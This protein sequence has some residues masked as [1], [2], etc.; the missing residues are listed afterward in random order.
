[1]K[2]TP[3][4][5]ALL[6]CALFVV[7]S[8]TYARAV[9]LLEASDEAAHFLYT[10]HLLVDR[11]LPV[12]STREQ[13]ADEDDLARRWSVESHHPPLYYAIGALLIS[14]TQRADLEAYLQPNPLIFLRGIM[15]DNH[16]KWL[17]PLDA[18][19][20]TALAIWILRGYSLAL[21]VVTLWLIY[22][23]AT[24]AMG[25]TVGLIALLIAAH[26]PTLLNIGSSVNNDNLVTLLYTAGVYWTLRLWHQRAIRPRDILAISAIL[27]A[28]ALTK[29]TGLTLFAVVYGGVLLGVWRGHYPLRAALQLIVISLGVAAVGA[30]WWYLRNWTL[31]GDPIA[32]AM[33]AT[34][35][36]RE[37]AKPTE[38]GDL[39]A[40]LSRV[41]RSFWMMTGHLHQPVWGATWGYLYVALITVLGVAGI[42]RRRPRGDVLLLLGG[43]VVLLVT[44][45]A[46]GT[47]SIDISYGRL[48][49]PALVGFIPLMAF[50]W[51]QLLGRFAPLLVIPLAVWAWQFPL[52]TLPAAYPVLTPVATLPNDAVPVNVRA[53]DL[54]IVGYQAHTRT[55]TAGDPLAFSLYLR[56]ENPQN[57]ALFVTVL[58]PI[59][60]TAYATS[61]IYPGGAPTDTRP[62][63]D[64]LYHAPIRL[65]LPDDLPVLSPRQLRLQLGWQAPLDTD[66]LPLT[67][68]DN[69]PL[70]A[71]VLDAAV[72]VDARYQPPVYPQ[73]VEG[74]TFGDA[75]R[76]SSYAVTQQDSALTVDLAWDVA[77]PL[78]GD[79][80]LTVQLLDSTQT[81]IA[82]QDGA[83]AG[84]PSAAWQGGTRF[85]ESRTLTLPD[86]LPAGAY[87][88]WL[89]WYELADFTRLQVTVQE[90]DSER[91]ANTLYLLETVTVR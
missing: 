55:A 40:E 53:G 59:T 23:A 29:I 89:G 43:V 9:P 58:D 7:L 12:I 72:L 10:H 79:W 49:F 76:L 17:H 45:L 6:I 63:A 78:T 36:G 32:S 54:A 82:Q 14:P 11:G 73:A 2:L 88:V 3:N 64:T 19:G 34:L 27:C 70:D 4:R 47:R 42:I 26:L 38:S 33:T 31:Y 68:G 80:V 5:L 46:V 75:L 66:Y 69:A 62:N 51:R 48:L 91:T 37:F 57:P 87:H 65:Q 8:L 30:G 13:I 90:Q 60:Q 25:S 50:G 35:W 1:M 77:A 84:Y 52:T 21:S 61:A 24:L 16:N 20:D 41:G 83:I 28:I 81:L 56:G 39:L 71:L 15:A 44:T 18:N 74:V 86:T 67:A 22:Q 85:T